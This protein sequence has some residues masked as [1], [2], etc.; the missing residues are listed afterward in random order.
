VFG[1][2][3]IPP[4]SHKTNYISTSTEIYN[5][6]S[7]IINFL[8]NQCLY[9]ISGAVGF[10]ASQ[11]R[12]IRRHSMTCVTRRDS[13]LAAGGLAKVSL[14][15]VLVIAVCACHGTTVRYVYRSGFRHLRAVL[16]SLA[17]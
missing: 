14:A 9:H 6:F 11:P 12:M 8:A 17:F 2:N 4:F 15:P 10:T 13:P 5:R 16:L 3:N 1:F 7:S